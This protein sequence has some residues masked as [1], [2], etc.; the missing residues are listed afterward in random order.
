MN[1][2]RI[3]LTGL[4]TLVACAVSFA[5]GPAS[6]RFGIG[7]LSFF[8]SSR[9]YGMGGVGAGLVGDQFINRLNPAG[10][11]GISQTR[12]SGT[13]LYSN[14]SSTD[15]TGSARYA[16][17]DF[18]GLAVAIPVSKDYGIVLVGELTPYSTVNYAINRSDVQSGIASDQ[19]YYG[20]GGISRFDV[21]S[22]VSLTNQLHAGF[23]INYLA[24]TILKTTK[25]S[26]ADNTVA[27]SEVTVNSHY[28]GLLFSFGATYDGLSDL[29]DV[30]ILKSLVLGAVVET[31]ATLDLKVQHFTSTASSYDTISTVNGKAD[32]PLFLAFGASYTLA[33][34]YVF[35]ADIAMQN[36]SGA[37]SLDV[38]PTEFRSST[39][40]GAGV[41][42][43]P[44]K[45]PGSYL[46]HVVYRAGFYYDASY[47]RINNQ[48]INGMF[49]TAGLGL[50]IGPE[51]YLNLGLQYGVNGTTANGLQK[52]SIFRLTAS[53]SGSEL[54]FV[55]L[56]ED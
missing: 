2:K 49:L 10:L 38:H 8:A 39:R 12:F 55:R 24:G 29:V 56:E 43:L 25:L 4:S 35:A 14:Y 28:S 1:R 18:G 42:I 9:S 51:S 5:G 6:S 31:P 54:W 22:S 13:F 45:N 46:G 53:I 52:D 26:F 21:G 20:S 40:I 30:P 47:L 11:A 27:S 34:R 33:E 7:D 17:G 15:A 32:I 16:R 19:R 41:E 44:G 23:K 37:K 50:P 3:Y 36:W 48:D